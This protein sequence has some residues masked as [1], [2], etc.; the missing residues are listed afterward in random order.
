[1]TQSKKVQENKPIQKEEKGIICIHCHKKVT[2][3]KIRGLS[4]VCPFCDRP[5]DELYD[6][7][8]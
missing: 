4:L 5:S 6:I 7:K 2:V 3:A 8:H 1:M